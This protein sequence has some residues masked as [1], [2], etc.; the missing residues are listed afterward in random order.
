MQ[1]A[2]HIQ[3]CFCCALHKAAVHLELRPRDNRMPLTKTP[4]LCSE[5][6][7]PEAFWGGTIIVP[8]HS[9]NVICQVLIIVIV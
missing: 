3:G 6:D 7:I 5:A 2:G 9:S 8:A 4:V 1:L